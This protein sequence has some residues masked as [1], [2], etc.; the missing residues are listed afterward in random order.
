MY[1]IPIVSTDIPSEALAAEDLSGLSE[2][3][4]SDVRTIH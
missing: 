1:I 2:A 3:G 4:P